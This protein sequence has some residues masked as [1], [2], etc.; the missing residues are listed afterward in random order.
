MRN[1]QTNEKRLN[2]TVIT[3]ETDL[4]ESDMPEIYE[5]EKI[6]ERRYKRVRLGV[7]FVIPDKAG[8]GSSVQYLED[9][10]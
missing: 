1:E 3:K 9:E 6:K 7:R 10:S 2:P 5:E 8:G 4:G